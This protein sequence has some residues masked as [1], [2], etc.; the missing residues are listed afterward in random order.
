MLFVAKV[1][2]IFEDSRHGFPSE[3]LSAVVAKHVTIA[4]WQQAVNTLVA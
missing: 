4:R 1:V 2:E 3:G